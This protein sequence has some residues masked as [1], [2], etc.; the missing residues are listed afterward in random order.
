MKVVLSLIVAVVLVA[1]G[2]V[3]GFFVM[4]G[5]SER[6]L[7]S[8]SVE[9]TNTQTIE[10][11][12]REEQIVLLSL[13]IQ[14][15]SR[16]TASGEFLG[17]KIPGSDKT[18]FV[19]Y[20]FSAKLGVEGK[21][22]KI[23]KTG[24]REYLV[25]VPAFIFIGHDNPTFAEIDANG[26]LLSGF[27]EDIDTSQ[28]VNEILNDEAQQVYLEKNKQLLKDQVEAFY[29]GLSASIDPMAKLTFSY[30]N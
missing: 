28:M 2:G 14:G 24:E 19:E 8:T 11:I 18:K 4:K 3:V 23:A 27:A 5:V 25:S 10:S 1:V 30:V 20:T 22:V 9:S 29:K 12:T 6:S 13:G 26:G 7:L 15:L 21:D 16:K 17:Q